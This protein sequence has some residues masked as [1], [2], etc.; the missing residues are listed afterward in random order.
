MLRVSDL[1]RSISF[2]QQALELSLADT[3]PF[4]E[5]TLVYLRN[6]ESSFEL[7]LT[8]NHAQTEALVHGNLYG[9]LAVSVADIDAVHKNLT[10][11][12]LQPTKIKHLQWEEKKLA[13]LFFITDPDGYKIEF[14]ER[15]GRY[16]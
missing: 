12:N 3:F 14:I 5:F 7:E 15:G 16:V 2:Y 4:K 1:E 9:H 8:F 6:K 11:L 13:K 10:K